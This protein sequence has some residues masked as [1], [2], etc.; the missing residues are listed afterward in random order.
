MVVR[1]VDGSNHHVVP[2]H[3]GGGGSSARHT[4]LSGGIFKLQL[5][6]KE[7][8]DEVVSVAGDLLDKLV[9]RVEGPSLGNLVVAVSVKFKDLRVPVVVEGGSPEDLNS[10]SFPTLNVVLNGP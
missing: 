7:F 2:E 4:V 5:E 10:N 6:G 9:L 8:A 1:G 3:V